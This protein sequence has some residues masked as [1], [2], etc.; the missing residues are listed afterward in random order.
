M[1]RELVQDKKLRARVLE[2]VEEFLLNNKAGEEI[3]FRELIL[4]LLTADSS[5]ISAYK[6]LNN[7]YSHDIKLLDREQISVILRDSGYRFYNLKSRYIREAI[8]KYYGRIKILVKPI[9]DIDQFEARE[10][11]VNNV[12]GLGYKEA[13]HF[14]RNL[15]Y[16]ELAIIDRHILRYVN[17]NLYVS[18]KKVDNKHRYLLVE[19]LLR[20]IASALNMQV[21]LLD[22]F[23]FFKQTQT[24]VK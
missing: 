17:T 1:L 19:G 10:F 24:L 16:F 2:R 20:A 23:I 22:L 3:W 14:L 5:F 6:A 15:G 9:A 8:E 21:G 12:K 13:S 18:V 4:C 11:L 7:L